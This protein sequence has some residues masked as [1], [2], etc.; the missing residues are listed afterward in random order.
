MFFHLI[1][2][3]RPPLLGM[4]LSATFVCEARLN[5]Q[6]LCHGRGTR[7]DA[8]PFYYKPNELELAEQALLENR[9]H[10]RQVQFTW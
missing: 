1:C 4:F 8:S 9:L 6:P 7:E 2:Y 5:A 3:V 10:R